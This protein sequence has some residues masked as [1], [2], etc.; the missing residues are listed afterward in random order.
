M[1]TVKVILRK[2]KGQEKRDGSLFSTG[3]ARTAGYQRKEAAKR[4]NS[5]CRQRWF[6][7]FQSIVV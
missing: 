7:V 2:Q 1:L 4:Q 3:E 6:N 5:C